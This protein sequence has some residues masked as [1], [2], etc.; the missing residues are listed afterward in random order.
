MQ[1][2]KYLL[3]SLPLLPTM[4]HV[5]TFN[6]LQTQNTINSKNTPTNK[7][8]PKK[9]IRRSDLCGRRLGRLAKVVD[10]DDV[11]GEALVRL[12]WRE[13]SF[14]RP[15]IC[16]K[17]KRWIFHKNNKHLKKVVWCPREKNHYKCS[18]L[19]NVWVRSSIIIKREMMWDMGLM[20]LCHRVPLSPGKNSLSQPAS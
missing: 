12:M 17:K 11:G 8:P 13:I 16:L 4:L 9:T 3:P 1:N 14:G 18:F 6:P 2:F 19:G 5:W 15:D 10:F 20:F 7:I